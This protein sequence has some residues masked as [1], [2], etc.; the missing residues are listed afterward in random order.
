MKIQL[1]DYVMERIVEE[2]VTDI[3]LVSGGGSMFLLNSLGNNKKLNYI[4]NHHEQASVMSAEAYARITGGLGVALVSTGPAGTNALTGVACAWNDSIPLLVI[5]GQANSKTLIGKTGLRQRGVHEVDI[6]EIV[7]PITKYAVTITDERDIKY[8]LDKA[9]FLARSGRPGPVWIDIPIDIQSKMIDPAMQFGFEFIKDNYQTKGFLDIDDIKTTIRLIQ[10]SK[11]P[12]ILAGHGIRLSE[13]V[14]EFFNFLAIT[15]IPVVTTKNGFDIIADHNE[16]LA[17]RVGT[18]GQRAGNFAIQNSDLVI[19]LGSRLSQPVT[20]YEFDLFARDAKK[21][22]VD[23]DAIQLQNTNIKVDLKIRLDLKQFFYGINP[24][25]RQEQLPDFSEWN[26]RCQQYRKDFPV[27]TQEMKDRT[28]YID[29]YYFY[30]VLSQEADNDDILVTDQ[31][32]AFYAFTTSYKLK[33]GQRAFTNGG[34]S[35]MGYGLPASIG[36]CIANKKQRIL[37]VH[38]DGGLEMN[39]QELQTIVHNKLPI[40]IFVFNNQGYT[41]IKHTQNGY[42][43]G[44]FVGSERDSGVT[45]P[46]FRRIS[47]AYNIKYIHIEKNS[48]LKEWIGHALNYEGAML[49]EVMIDPFQPFH[50]RVMTEKK[51]DGK[52]VSKPIEDMYPFLDRE[53]FKKQMIVETVNE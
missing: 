26:N 14:N 51:A 32:I 22:V 42:F 1:A 24:L 16:L 35:P 7:K 46:D 8:H 17:G 19:V 50:P 13:A 15:E 30:E 5:S 53:L 29:P 38:G 23:I 49:I 40:K 48:D 34:F 36:A 52:L 33:S 45:C 37:S 2:G 6:V 25:L 27:V 43:D 9:I 18:Y 12:I 28:D 31:G 21:I 11:R 39:I 10:E 47:Y 41:S 44:H 4:C 20:G 3:F